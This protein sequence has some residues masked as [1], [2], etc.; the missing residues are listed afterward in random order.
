MLSKDENNTV[1]NQI[2]KKL[3]DYLKK[4]LYF[5]HV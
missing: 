3:K 2:S 1:I 5:I 4:T